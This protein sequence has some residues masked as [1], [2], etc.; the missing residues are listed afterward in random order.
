MFVD[1]YLIMRAQQACTGANIHDVTQLLSIY[2]GYAELSSE[3]PVYETR[4]QTLERYI[5]GFCVSGKCDPNWR[6]TP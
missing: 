6:Q 2:S 5:R 3:N 1:H 4:A